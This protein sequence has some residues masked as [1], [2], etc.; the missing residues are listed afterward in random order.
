VLE[1]TAVVRTGEATFTVGGRRFTFAR[2]GREVWLAHDGWTWHIT[3]ATAEDVH[4]AHADG[5]LRAPMPGAVLLTPTCVG[6]AVE[7]GQTVVVIES[8]KMELALAA[9][10]AGTV[11]ELLVS[12]GDKVGRDEVVAKV[13]AA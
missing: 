8:M 11:T 4:H 7:A 1:Q 2:D 13:E 5:E 10:V 3:E 6:D 12:V 9:P